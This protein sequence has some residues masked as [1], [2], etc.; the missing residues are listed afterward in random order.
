MPIVSHSLVALLDRIR[1]S[2]TDPGGIR[3]RLAPKPD[4]PL[5]SVR[6]STTTTA[7]T[8]SALWDG[9]GDLGG[10]T[11]E[12]RAELADEGTLARAEAYG[13]NVERMIGT[14]KVPVGVVGP[15]RV[16]GVDAS[17]DYLVPLATTE[18][19]LVASY[20]RGA[21][22]VSQ[23]GGVSAAVTS[24]GVARTPGFAFESLFD[25]G[26]F[27]DWVARNSDA[28]KS[29]AEATSRHARLVG[30]E[31]LVDNDLVFLTC[32]YV[33]GDAS[34]QNMVTI[35]TN[36]LCEHVAAHCPVRIRHHFVEVN[37]SGDKKASYVNLVAGRG[38]RVTASVTLPGPLVERRLRTTTSRV[39]DYARFA[40][41]GALL[42]GQI[43]AQGHYANGLAALYLATGQDVACVAESAVG[44]TRMEDRGG[45]LFVS[46]TLPNVLVGTVGGGTGLPSQ[47]A[48]LRLMGLHGTGHAAALAE[49]TAALCLAGE[50]SIIGALAS[51]DFVRA[52]RRLARGTR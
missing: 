38:R 11:P 29:V 39:M 8:V 30:I 34:G 32:R 49:V 52:H 14:V 27:V 10:A 17:G 35:A 44:F 41:L 24:E 23:A 45:D 3:H 16:N 20:A 31:P 2:A 28:L 13:R 12:D 46:V 50:V 18:A 6:A 4:A 43:G 47:S 5:A 51:G 42:S 36:A 40:N 48:S 1:S 25:A 21:T 37:Y 22:I 19:A 7:R 26:L 33:T 15:L 9:M